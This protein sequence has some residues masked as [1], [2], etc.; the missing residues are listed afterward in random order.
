MPRLIMVAL[1]FKPKV[2]VA[3]L[4]KASVAMTRIKRLLVPLVL[5]F[6]IGLTIS[7]NASSKKL[8]GLCSTQQNGGGIIG[9]PSQFNCNAPFGNVCCY[10]I[11]GGLIYY[12]LN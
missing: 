1:I 2:F 12:K 6:S 8:E 5:L 4:K 10:S 11:P 3:F 7:V 9:T